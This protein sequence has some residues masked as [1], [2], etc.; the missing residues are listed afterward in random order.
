MKS[1]K[2]TKFNL[3]AKIVIGII[4]LIIKIVKRRKQRKRDKK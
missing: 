2:L 3:F 1:K 4:K